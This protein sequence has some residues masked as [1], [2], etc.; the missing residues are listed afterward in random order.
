MNILTINL[1]IIMRNCIKLYQHYI[2]VR[3]NSTVMWEQLER[4][5][6]L[7][8]FL[9]VDSKTIFTLISTLKTLKGRDIPIK[10]VDSAEKIPDLISGDEK[11]NLINC[12][13][14]HSIYYG[15]PQKLVDFGEYDCKSW[16]GY[17]ISQ[18][19]IS[20]YIWGYTPA[21]EEFHAY[22]DDTTFKDC[23]FSLDVTPYLT[24]LDN[25]KSE[26]FPKV[27]LVVVGNSDKYIPYKFRFIWEMLNAFFNEL[28][29]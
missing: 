3:E 21:S 11:I 7:E 23:E 26:D 14:F 2:D 22:K 20:N 4:D 29:G 13:Y 12:D 8:K 18:H 27:D 24:V 16:V 9:S 10:F 1:N 15:N 6:G 17:L 25:I 5:L 19:H 28:V